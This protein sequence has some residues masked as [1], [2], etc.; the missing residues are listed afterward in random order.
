[1]FG[2]EIRI[3]FLYHQLGCNFSQTANIYMYVYRVER[4][5]ERDLTDGQLV[6]N[7]DGIIGTPLLLSLSP[8]P[9]LADIS[10]LYAEL[11]WE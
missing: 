11:K 2:N 9:S 8:S 5:R 4:E 10:F 6:T 7:I 1:M 3:F